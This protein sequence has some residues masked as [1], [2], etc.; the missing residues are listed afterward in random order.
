MDDDPEKQKDSN[1]YAYGCDVFQSNG[2]RYYILHD[3]ERNWFIWNYHWYFLPTIT[4]IS[5]IVFLLF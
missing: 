2:L 4:I 5:W 1:N 3:T